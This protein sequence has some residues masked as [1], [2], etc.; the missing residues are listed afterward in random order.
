MDPITLAIAGTALNGLGG[1][2]STFG[3]A[4]SAKINDRRAIEE[5]T[6]LWQQVGL[7]NEQYLDAMKAVEMQAQQAVEGRIEDGLQTKAKNAAWM[8]ASGTSFNAS[9]AIAAQQTDKKVARDAQTLEF[10]A[11]MQNKR[12]AA[13]IKV[14]RMSLDTAKAKVAA[15]ISQGTANTIGTAESAAIDFA[16]SLIKNAPAMKP[17]SGMTKG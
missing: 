10:N 14:N 12:I 3:A 17:P 2:L 16:G 11:A 7:Q 4:R 9:Q 1:L 8:S 6:G 13:Q 5:Y 15:T